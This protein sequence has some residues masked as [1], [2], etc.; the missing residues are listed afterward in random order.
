MSDI[1]K[2]KASRKIKIRSLEEYYLMLKHKKYIINEIKSD[3][4][5]TRLEQFLD[6]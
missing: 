3:L 5:G 2:A 1:D 6:E 4:K